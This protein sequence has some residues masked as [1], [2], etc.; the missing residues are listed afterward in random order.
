MLFCEGTAHRPKSVVTTFLSLDAGL[1]LVGV[2]RDRNSLGK[3]QAV[4][5]TQ[6]ALRA[7]R[8]GLVSS[9]K[10]SV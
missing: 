1:E 6:A 9:T 5:G 10:D 7:I 3:L 4:S 2:A 8:I